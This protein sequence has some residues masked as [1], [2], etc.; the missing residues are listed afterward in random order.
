MAHFA[1]RVHRQRIDAWQKL[2]RLRILREPIHCTVTHARHDGTVPW[3]RRE[4]LQWEPIAIGSRWGGLWD[5]AW[6]HLQATVPAQWAGETVVADVDCGGEALVVDAQGEPRCGLSNGSVFN[7]ALT[8]SIVPLFASAAGGEAVD[9]WIDGA[10]NALWGTGDILDPEFQTVPTRLHGHYDAVLGRAALHRFDEATRQ[11][12]WDVEVLLDLYDCLGPEQLRSERI[13]RGLSAACDIYDVHGADVARRHLAPLLAL[14]ADPATITLQA[15]GHAHIDT[16]WLWPVRETVRKCARTFSTALD[17]IARYP[18]YVF[19]ASQAAHYAMIEERHPGLFER[20]R[21]A[22]ADGRWEVQGGMWVEADCNLIGGEAMIRQFLYGKHYFLDR[23]GI[24]VRNLWLPDVFGYSGNLPQIMA[25]SGCPCFLTQKLSWNLY[26][27]FPHHSFVWRGIDGSE[28]VAH[29]PPEDDYNAPATPGSL[30]KA[31][32][33]FK[34]RGFLDEAISLFGV[35]DGGGGPGVEHLERARRLADCNGV[36]RYRMGP[37]QPALDR[38]AARRGELDVWQGELYFEL[39][40]GTLTTQAIT[41]MLNRRAEEALRATEML[42][43][44]AGSGPWP[45]AELER[46]WKLLL[47]NQFHDILPGSSIRLVYE[48][49]ERELREVVDGCRALQQVAA[50]GAARADTQALSLFNPSSTAFDDIIALPADW[51]GAMGE[52]GALPQQTASDGTVRVRVRVPGQRGSVLRRCQEPAPRESEGAAGP[53]DL[54]LANELVRY[55]F[56]RDLRLTGLWDERQ[57]RQLLAPDAPALVFRLYEDRPARYDAWDIDEWYRRCHLADAGVQGPIQRCT[58]PAHASLSARLLVD[59]TTIDCTVSL[60]PGS[61]RLDVRCRIDWQQTHRMLRLAV[62]TALRSDTAA[63]EI[64]YGVVHRA[65]HRNTLADAAC[66]E[67]A[68]QRYVDLSDASGGLAVLNDCK[69]GH[70]IQ[71]GLIDVAL[72]R[73]P[74]HPDPEADRGEQ[75][76]LPGLVWTEHEGLVQL[77]GYAWEDLRLPV[78]LGGMGLELTAL[79]RAEDGDGL[80][81]RVVETRGLRSSGRLLLPSDASSTPIDLV[82]LHEEPSAACTG[83]RALQLGPYEILSFRIR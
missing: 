20:I 21:G 69:H 70:H 42:C 67:S 60:R 79:K 8:K 55:E 58:G 10:A 51:P 22:V 71:D 1:T 27:G 63:F 19:G 7:P 66:F 76:R 62:P 44:A 24:E 83:E 77:P 65:I 3:S 29:F 30:K 17:L 12:A 25:K 26:T 57:G 43:C 54:V 53:D 16:G 9:L 50:A 36:P 82:E 81:V 31:E 41:K 13:L 68:A 4:E 39:H 48:R 78:G 49:T 80:I 5:S 11:L 64:Q 52:S 75:R 23:F 33:N 18:D 32:R 38:L 47:L 28:V 15:V 56:D 59:G 40:R 37:A 6:F 46:L 35:G 14:P 45:G 74:T 2:L 34:E 61:A 73:A 72:L